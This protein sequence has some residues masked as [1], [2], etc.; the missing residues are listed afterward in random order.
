ME[1]SSVSFVDVLSVSAKEIYKLKTPFL[2]DATPVKT[3]AK[4]ILSRGTYDIYVGAL[5]EDKLPTYVI[6]N[7]ETGVVEFTSEV[8]PVIN[9]WL[10]HFLGLPDPI[11]NL[12]QLDLNL[13][14]KN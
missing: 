4:P 6:L 12:E 10:N 7:R 2:F 14:A 5:E 1:L 9:D 8:L 11:P 3:D 13:V